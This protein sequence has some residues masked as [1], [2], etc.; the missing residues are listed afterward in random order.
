M[1]I[2]SA[3]PVLAASSVLAGT[4]LDNIERGVYTRRDLI[5]VERSIQ[6]RGLVED[7]WEKIKNAATC[8]GCHVSGQI[9]LAD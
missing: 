4:G 3:L 9:L 5:E 7:I 8:T 1:R 2:S 6:A